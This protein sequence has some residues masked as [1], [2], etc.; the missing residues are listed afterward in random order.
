MR[1]ILWPAVAFILGLA[2]SQIGRW[3]ESAVSAEGPAAVELVAAPEVAMAGDEPVVADREAL[4]QLI[5][6]PSAARK[7]MRLL[8]VDTT[9]RSTSWEQLQHWSEAELD[10]VARYL[11]WMATEGGGSA[12]EVL[13]EGNTYRSFMKAYAKRSP[14]K[15]LAWAQSY[16]SE[17]ARQDLMLPAYAAMAATDLQATLRN[18]DQ[19]H[20]PGV[21]LQLKESTVALLAGQQ[22]A[23]ALAW[24]A[25]HGTR[26]TVDDRAVELALEN[27]DFSSVWAV[28]QGLLQSPGKDHLLSTLIAK[29]GN[30]PQG[31]EILEK[32]SAHGRLWTEGLALGKLSKAQASDV[33][34]ASF[35]ALPSHFSREM[36][37]DAAR[38]MIN[39]AGPVSFMQDRHWLSS[40][41]HR[42]VVMEVIADGFLT[43]KQERKQDLGKLIRQLP[44]D[45]RYD[46]LQRTISTRKG[47]G[48]V[49]EELWPQVKQQGLDAGVVS[50]AR[51]RM[52]SRNAEAAGWLGSIADARLR[53]LALLGS[54]A[55]KDRQQRLATLTQIKTP[56]TRSAA[57][58]TLAVS[59]IRTDATAG[60]AWARSQSLS[61][62]DLTAVQQAVV[63]GKPGGVFL[64]NGEWLPR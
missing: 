33:W 18:I 16:P 34:E 8:N 7:A 25:A 13:M 5:R 28:V 44:E 60:M 41:A 24:L 14:S 63:H 4:I 3:D 1:S 46:V 15:A 54:L 42:S 58:K 61:A 38:Q 36:A 11:H 56:A 26:G 37:M 10:E 50:Y 35:G 40:E 2:L 17:W 29:A 47:N 6:Q 64:P 55:E 23:V 30:Y 52:A 32:E 57:V 12:V 62:A 31:L 19:A 20:T 27:N 45:V 9:G 43:K 21:A 51:E 22:P 59:W 48:P 53:E 49:L 39:S